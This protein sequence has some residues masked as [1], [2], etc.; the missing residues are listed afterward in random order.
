MIAAHMCCADAHALQAPG[1][2]VV[3]KESA[4]Q[5]LL[6]TWAQR[7]WMWAGV[8]TSFRTTVPSPAGQMSSKGEG[9]RQTLSGGLPTSPKC[10]HQTQ[11]LHRQALAAVAPAQAGS[12]A[13]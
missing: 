12:E 11:A 8:S 2:A 5:T 9:G 13:R 3:C 10:G 7:S 1:S 4:A 6:L